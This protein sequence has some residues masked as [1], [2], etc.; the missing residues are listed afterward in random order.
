MAMRKG[1]NGLSQI[2][3][4]VRRRAVPQAAGAHANH[5]QRMALRQ[6][7]DVPPS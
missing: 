6:A 7:S 4:P 3:I 5:L 1:D 2:D